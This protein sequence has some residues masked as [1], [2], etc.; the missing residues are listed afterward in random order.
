MMK[1]KLHQSLAEL[2]SQRR[3]SG[4]GCSWRDTTAAT[5]QCCG[6][7]EPVAVGMDMTRSPAKK[8]QAAFHQHHREQHGVSNTV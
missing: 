5:L 3:A 6:Q 4:T 1:Q 8:G 2:H 7:I